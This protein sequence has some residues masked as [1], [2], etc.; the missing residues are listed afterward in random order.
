MR[1]LELTLAAVLALHLLISALL[2]RRQTGIPGYIALL[3]ALIAFAQLLIEGYRWQML[4]L[5]AYAA[6]LAGQ[7]LSRRRKPPAKRPS[8]LQKMWRMLGAG[9]ALVLA[10]LL[11]NLLAVP[12]FPT[13]SGPHPVGTTSFEL[14]DPS[15]AEIY[16][17]NPG[18]PR[19][20]LVEPSA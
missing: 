18:Q 1:P 2:S 11:P 19:A 7:T 5:Y 20:L 15:R 17:D 13:P 10:L 14:V 12:Q 6:V 16:G 4:P 9:L 3:A 8:S